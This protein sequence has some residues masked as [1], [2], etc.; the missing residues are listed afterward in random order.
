[1][2]TIVSSLEEKTD[3]NKEKNKTVY[4]P[5]P[6]PEPEIQLFELDLFHGISTDYE[7]YKNDPLFNYNFID[8]SKM[9]PEE[10]EM[11]DPVYEVTIEN[12]EIKINYKINTKEWK[13]YDSFYRY[14]E[15][16]KITEYSILGKYIGC[17]LSD[18][19]KIFGLPEEVKYQRLDYYFYH[20]SD[21]TSGV[22]FYHENNIITKIECGDL[23]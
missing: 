13:H 15:I 7:E 11:E 3:E 18:I 6:R 2:K 4:E 5:I 1:M 8:Y 14:V 10:R 21:W 16:K 22:T 9:R 19:E 23:Y 20:D 12:D 17:E